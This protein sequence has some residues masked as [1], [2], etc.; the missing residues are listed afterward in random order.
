MGF[1]HFLQ[2]FLSDKAEKLLELRLN[3]L[4]ILV[5]TAGRTDMV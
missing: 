1:A 3:V 2:F 4:E 5:T